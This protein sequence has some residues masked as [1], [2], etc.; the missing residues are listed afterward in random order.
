MKEIKDMPK[1]MEKYIPA[2]MEQF[3]ASKSE[4]E[5]KSDLLSYRD[6]L[7]DT[8]YGYPNKH[9]FDINMSIKIS[10]LEILNRDFKMD[11]L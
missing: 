10:F 3:F 5:N 2:M 7:S 6:S 9:S 8:S 4:I 11:S 1:W